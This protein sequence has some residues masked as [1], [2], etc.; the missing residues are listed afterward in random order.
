M[1]IAVMKE[2]QIVVGDYR[3]L[4]PNTSFPASGPSA[5]WIA[6]Q[7]WPVTVFK[8]H[9]RDTQKLVPVAPYVEDGQVFTV[10]VEAKTQAEID[11]ETTSLAAQVRSRRDAELARSDWRVIKAAETGVALDAAWAAYRQA[12]RDISSQPGFPSVEIPRAPD[13]VEM[14]AMQSV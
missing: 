12:L 11:A 2:G 5:E 14:T 8:A 9:D 13:Y 1:N 6:E 3:S 4:F 7:G 10:T